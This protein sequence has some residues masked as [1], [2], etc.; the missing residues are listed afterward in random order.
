[1]NEILTLRSYPLPDLQE[2]VKPIWSSSYKWRLCEG[3]IEFALPTSNKGE[4]WFHV[5]RAPEK[6]EKFVRAWYQ[7]GGLNNFERMDQ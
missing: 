2:L 7:S 6:V 4:K 1:M 5:S 3:R